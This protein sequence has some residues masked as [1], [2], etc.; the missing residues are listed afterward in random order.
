MIERAFFSDWLRRYGD[1]WRAGDP[2]AVLLLFT[3]DAAY[4]ETPFEPPLLGRAAIRRY[5]TE[6]ARDG[7][8]DVAFAAQPV[9]VDG[10][11][12]CALWQ[13]TFVRQPAG[14]FVEL[15]GVLLARFAADGRCREFREW[16]HRRET[17]ARR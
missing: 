4:H 3:D 12:G 8:R 15:D 13:A 1:A 11:T 10:D 14:S 6:G 5:W 17:P 9:G 7:Q 2:Q 16:W